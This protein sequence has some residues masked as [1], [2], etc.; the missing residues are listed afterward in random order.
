MHF[1][2]IRLCVILLN[3]FILYDKINNV[4]FYQEMTK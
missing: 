2:S 4:E 3:F 1:G